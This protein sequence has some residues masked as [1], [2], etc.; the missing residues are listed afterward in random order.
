MKDTRLRLTLELAFYQ[1]FNTCPLGLEDC[2]LLAV[3]I[4]AEPDPTAGTKRGIDKL[5]NSAF[6]RWA[7]LGILQRH[8]MIHVDKGPK[9]CGR[10]FSWIGKASRPP[11]ELQYAMET[12]GSG[13][14]STLVMKET[15]LR[16]TLELAG[17]QSFSTWPLGLEDCNLLAVWILAEPDP[18]AG[19]KRGIDKLSRWAYL[20]IT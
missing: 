3:W 19:T 20:S 15:R 16:L 17:H 1:N 2:N 9:E 13:P 4:L 11:A 18:T 12:D 10:L 14:T 6:Q 5:S 8:R 7:Y